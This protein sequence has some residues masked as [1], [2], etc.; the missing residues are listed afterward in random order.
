MQAPATVYETLSLHKFVYLQIITNSNV[1]EFNKNFHPD[2]RK[3]G[4]AIKIVNYYI[5][6]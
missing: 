1:F 4:T 2:L 6:V 5:T 3:I